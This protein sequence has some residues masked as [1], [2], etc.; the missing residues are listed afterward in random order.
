MS[1]GEGASGNLE[2]AAA[3]PRG[4]GSQRQQLRQRKRPIVTLTWPEEFGS[5]LKHRTGR[6]ACKLFQAIHVPLCHHGNEVHWR[7]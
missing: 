6:N 1:F 2:N 7:S 4:S 5:Y 3:Y